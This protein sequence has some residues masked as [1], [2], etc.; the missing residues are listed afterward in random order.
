MSKVMCDV[1]ASGVEMIRQ[2]LER[3]VKQGELPADT[4]IEALARYF[5][6]VSN[7][8]SV[9]AASGIPTEKL[10]ETISIA[11]RNWPEVS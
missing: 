1:R 5:G 7:G 6:A 8:V 4:D 2:C 3:G 9:Q 10:H 11:M